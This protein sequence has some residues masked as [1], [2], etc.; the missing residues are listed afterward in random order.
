[1]KKSKS[2]TRGKGGIRN[3]LLGA[4]IIWLL[5]ILFSFILAIILFSGD[6]PTASTA[7]FSIIAFIV[8]GALGTLINRRA[9]RQSA[10]NVPLFSSLLCAFIYAVISAVASGRISFGALITAICFIGASI[11]VSIPKRKKAK[12]HAR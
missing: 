5:F 10:I 8:S 9:F 6:D 2:D 1:M 11:L 7:L 4:L 12:R 3:T